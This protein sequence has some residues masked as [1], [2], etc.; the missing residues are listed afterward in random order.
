[1]AAHE[2]EGQGVVPSGGGL[3]RL[4]GPKSRQLLSVTT[5]RFAAE[6]VDHAAGGDADQ[7]AERVVGHAVGGPGGGRS[8]QGQ[9]HRVLGIGEVAVAPDDDAEGPRR[10]L[11]Q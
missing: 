3:C 9:L 8:D 7:P 10:E 11:A 1:M 4:R 5:R 6:L 2:E